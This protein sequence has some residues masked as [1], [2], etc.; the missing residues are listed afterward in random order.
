MLKN[1][2][3]VVRIVGADVGF[4]TS[5]GVVLEYNPLTKK[6]LW[7]GKRIISSRARQGSNLTGDILNSLNNTYRVG[8]IDYTVDEKNNG[9][10]V[11]DRKE[12]HFS[13]IQ[14]VL[15]QHLLQNLQLKN[16]DNLKIV[17]GMPISLFYATNNK[18]NDETIGR[19]QENLEKTVVTPLYNAEPIAI[20]N[21]SMLA[22]GVGAYLD[23]ILND[24]GEFV[25]GSEE[26]VVSIIDIGDGTTDIVTLRDVTVVDFDRTASQNIGV[27]D[28]KNEVRKILERDYNVTD[29]TD[30]RINKMLY[31]RVYRVSG[32]DFSQDQIIAI[33]TEAVSNVLVR[34]TA[35]VKKTLSRSSDIDRILVVGGG[36][37]IY[38]PEIRALFPQA[39]DIEEPQ[40]ANARGFAKLGLYNYKAEN[41][42]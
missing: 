27:S 23:F 41:D 14:C 9:E 18:R 4:G 38:G 21:V 26:E 2:S 11:D 13:A 35:F 28:V 32:R 20:K 15:M 42:L 25:S 24:K 16:S 36:A 10:G 34:L 12:Y 22:E 8:N 7:L 33:L 37:T 1:N 6:T 3:E 19:K 30:F 40:L 39:V 29:E 5:I 31:N 17:S